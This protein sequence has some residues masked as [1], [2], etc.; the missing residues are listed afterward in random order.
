MQGHEHGVAC[1]GLQITRSDRRLVMCE[2]RSG[3]G[4]TFKLQGLMPPT[5]LFNLCDRPGP[6]LVVG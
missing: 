6:M 3:S 5:D 1:G 4:C 2:E